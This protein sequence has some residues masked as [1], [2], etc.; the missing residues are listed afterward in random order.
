M[1]KKNLRKIPRMVRAQLDRLEQRHVVGAAARIFTTA[2]LSGG[3]LAH[4]G[5]HGIADLI[6]DARSVIPAP[7]SGKYSARNANGDVVIRRDLPKEKHFHTVQAP[8]WGGNGTHPVDLPHEAYPREHRP[9]R[10]AQIRISTAAPRGDADRHLLIFELDWVLDR[11]DANFEADLLTSLNLLQENVGKCGV[12]KSGA[13]LADYFK[14]LEVEWELLPPGTKEEAVARLFRDREPSR[15][16]KARVED[17]YDFLMGLNPQ[18][19][20]YGASGF[21]RYFGAMIREDLVVFEN[22]E[23]GNAVYVMFG[24]WVPL[25]KRSR[26][27]LL[28]GRYGQ[29]FERIVHGAE[30]KE[31]VIACIRRHQEGR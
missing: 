13:T 5:V 28:S 23:Y 31:R 14:T 17:R 9:P 3:A 18:Q 19:L 2:S 11:K 7:T 12:Q 15:E 22:I 30:W 20:V 4:L 1:P 24:D 26:T 6:N 29:N 21:Q 8:N 27:D 16:E 25:S 10:L